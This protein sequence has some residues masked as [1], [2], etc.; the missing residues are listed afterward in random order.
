M[1]RLEFTGEIPL[2]GPFGKN[3]LENLK[4]LV[5]FQDSNDISPIGGGLKLPPASCMK[6]PNVRNLLTTAKGLRSAPLPKEGLNGRKRNTWDWKPKKI[7]PS[8]SWWIGISICLKYK[9]KNPI[10]MTS[11]GPIS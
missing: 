10:R 7:I 3:F 8:V 5:P 1:D 4:M 6:S 11:A 2:F 9:E